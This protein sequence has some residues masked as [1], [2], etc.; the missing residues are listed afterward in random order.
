MVFLLGW[1]RGQHLWVSE[2]VDSK[3]QLVGKKIFTFCIVHVLW[4]HL[5][6]DCVVATAGLG[7]PQ[8]LGVLP[9]A[10]WPRWHH[11]HPLWVWA[12]LSSLETP[13][14]V[15]ALVWE[16]GGHHAVVVAV[17]DHSS[18]TWG[19]HLFACAMRQ[20]HLRLTPAMPGECRCSPG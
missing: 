13:A 9:C 19:C 20:S 18:G 16:G 1:E 7:F 4:E 11:W 17:Q 5:E 8:M 2:L 10:G 12:Q 6:L 15:A 14:V 3:V